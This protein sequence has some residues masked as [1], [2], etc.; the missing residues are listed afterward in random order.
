[1]GSTLVT[2]PANLV[3]N[4]IFI[5]RGMQYTF[6]DR[7]FLV[8]IF[9]DPHRYVAMKTARQVSKSTTLAAKGLIACEALAPYTVL[10]L[11]PSRDQTSKFSHD[12]LGPTIQDSPAV[13]EL[14]DR[15]G[16]NNVMEKSF[17]NGSRYYLKYGRENADS[18]RGISCDETHYDEVQD[19]NLEPVEA[20]T[21]ECMFMSPHKKRMY[22][23]TPKS[24]SN[25]IE[26][27]IWR[28]SDQ[29]EWMVRCHHH[30]KYPYY[31]KLTLKSIGLQGPICDRCGNLVDTLDGQW[32]RTSTRT[33]DGKEPY[34]HGYHIPQ[35][36]FP[37]NKV[38]LPSGKMGILDWSEFLLE[39]ENSDEA[40]VLN[41][42]FGESADSADR[43]ITEEELRR[44]CDP[45]RTMPDEYLDWM[46]GDYTYA[47]I[48][49]GW[50]IKS[51]TALVIGQFEPG[52]SN[53]FRI[54]HCKKYFGDEA[55]PSFCIPDILQTMQRFRVRRC[56]ADFGSGLGLNSQIRDAC[57]EDFIT[58][59]YWSS[60]IS[61]KRIQYEQK[62]DR[63]VVNKAVS[64]SRFFLALKKR[65]ITIAFRWEDFKIFG[66][67]FL[68]EFREERRNGDPYYD[69]KQNE[70]DD[71]L[72]AACYAWLISSW[73]KY[74]DNFI[75]SAATGSIHNPARI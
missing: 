11:T 64:L 38:Q 62:L 74:N 17:V 29:R 6:D 26:Q 45:T 31:Q 36:L 65:A 50:G 41:E 44:C 24:H 46:I 73:L 16:V 52:N 4:R 8:D 32:I 72:H 48:D 22:S 33:D 30:G 5:K 67:D 69:H 18:S 40:T 3:A 60:S 34:I 59:N 53:N 75:D 49:W 21:R 10:S 58:S 19:M 35:I 51:A 28:R 9:D 14:L 13:V 37:T 1:M 12:R 63:F 68:N 54:V 43:P 56:H 7:P 70:P 47:G 25:G 57:G 71:F 39:I 66:Q 23:G 20:V 55:D 27:R 61:G 2:T 15:D 42:K